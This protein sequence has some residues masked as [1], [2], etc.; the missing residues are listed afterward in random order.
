MATLTALI[1]SV[2]DGI[3]KAINLAAP[4]ASGDPIPDSSVYDSM[5]AGFPMIDQQAQ[6]AY[7]LAA[8]I[9]GEDLEDWGYTLSEDGSTYEWHDMDPIPEPVSDRS[10]TAY[11]K[12]EYQVLLNPCK[13]RK[14][15]GNLS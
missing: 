6:E 1:H 13:E 12:V 10:S 7:D 3:N 14:I 4:L 2:I 15:S 11:V 9:M 5:L 8:E